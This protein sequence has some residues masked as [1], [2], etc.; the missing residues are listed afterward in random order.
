MLMKTLLKILLISAFCAFAW[1]LFWDVD[2]RLKSQEEYYLQKAVDCSS[3]YDLNHCDMTILPPELK[4]ICEE[5]RNCMKFDPS[6][7]TLYFK[8][9]AGLLAEVMNDFFETLSYATMAKF[10]SVLLICM[11]LEVPYVQWKRF[12]MKKAKWHSE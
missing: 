1:T 11:A 9:T 10:V 5:Y 3:Q 2:K 6:N 12:K 8:I 7:N 4:P